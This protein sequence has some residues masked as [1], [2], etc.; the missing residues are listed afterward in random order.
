MNNKKPFKVLIVDDLEINVGI[1][2][3]I[4]SS[5][6]YEPIGALSVSEALE[7]MNKDMPQLIL[8]DYSMPDMNG[9]EFC[10]LL[11]GNPKTRE[12]PFMLITVADSSDVKKTAFEAGVADYIS[13]PFERTEVIMRIRNQLDNY[14]AK[15]EIVEHNRMMHKVIAEQKAHVR[16]EQENLVLAL[17]KVIEGTDSDRKAKLSRISYNS[18]ILAQSLQLT[19][20]FEKEANDEFVDIIS[21]ASRL[22][23]I[24]C[25]MAPTV[26]GDKEA[27]SIDIEMQIR[28][29][30]TLLKE[31]AG[32]GSDSPFLDMAV[33]IAGYRHANWDGSGYPAVKGSS[34]PLAAR[35][36]SIVDDFDKALLG[37][38][39]QESALDDAVNEVINRSGMFY[40]PGIVKVFAKITKQIKFPLN[41]REDETSDN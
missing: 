7:L 31:I 5:E 26:N 22:Y 12:I 4:V 15:Q 37:K 2:E 30:E 9:I 10:K 6:G 21:V 33:S 16:K 32:I 13:K 20:E 8:S 29:G 25:L 17:A 41:K 14:K 1:L 40:D 3:H 36:V 23:D 38:P 28:E 11:K 18:R 39:D 34:I 35:I 19:E 27:F 24:G